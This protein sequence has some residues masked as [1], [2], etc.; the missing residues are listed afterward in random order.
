MT[1][2][3][4]PNSLRSNLLRIPQWGEK[5]EHR[6]CRHYNIF[7]SQRVRFSGV[8]TLL[9]LDQNFIHSDSRFNARALVDPCA[10]GEKQTSKGEEKFSCFVWKK[11]EYVC[12]PPS[13]RVQHSLFVLSSLPKCFTCSILLTQMGIRVLEQPWKAAGSPKCS[14]RPRWKFVKVSILF[15]S[16]PGILKSILRFRYLFLRF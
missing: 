7:L 9:N 4:P 12:L 13:W 1:V 2:V 3:T 16:H 6:L 14:C 5:W 8:P 15:V 11:V 10:H